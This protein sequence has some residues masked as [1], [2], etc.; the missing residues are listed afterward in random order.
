MASF[1][2]LTLMADF[3]FW[4]EEVDF[5]FWIPVADFRFSKLSS[6]TSSAI[7]FILL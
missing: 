2:F 3:G 4:I 5:V 7:F 1:G 6:L